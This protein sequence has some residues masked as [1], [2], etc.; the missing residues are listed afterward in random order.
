[1]GLMFW[2]LYE[3]VSVELYMRNKGMLKQE[4]GRHEWSES[5]K[6]IMNISNLSNQI[7]PVRFL[8]FAVSRPS[9]VM[10]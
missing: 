7:F 5:Q 8:P 4:K 9:A 6:W 3:Q 10:Q 1:M 2:F